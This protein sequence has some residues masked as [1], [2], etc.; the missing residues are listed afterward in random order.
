MRPIHPATAVGRLY[1]QSEACARC[2]SLKPGGML[3]WGAPV[4]PDALLIN[5]MRIYGPLRCGCGQSDLSHT[6][7]PSQ[8]RAHLRPTAARLRNDLS[9]PTSSLAGQAAAAVQ[10]L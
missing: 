3:F 2:R 8:R 10:G 6:P 9:P 5:A 4:G 7:T 1:T